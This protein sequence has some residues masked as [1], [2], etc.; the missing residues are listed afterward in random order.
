[1]RVLPDFTPNNVEFQIL[2]TSAW[3]KYYCV[4]EFAL[5][6]V[7]L[8]KDRFHQSCKE[9]FL[10]TSSISRWWLLVLEEDV[11]KYK[12]SKNEMDLSTL[13][14]R[15]MDN[16]DSYFEDMESTLVLDK[17]HFDPG[18]A[19]LFLKIFENIKPQLLKKIRRS[20]KD[21]IEN[22]F[23]SV[24]EYMSYLMEH[25]LHILYEMDYLYY[26]KNN[27]DNYLPFLSIDFIDVNLNI[28]RNTSLVIK[29]LEIYKEF[30]LIKEEQYWAV[31]SYCTR[32]YLDSDYQVFER[33]SKLLSEIELQGIRISCIM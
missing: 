23:H 31:K 22:N 29:R 28:D 9:I 3:K 12:Y 4:R 25:F 21:S 32:N 16:L 10:Y 5:N 15:S 24:V 8:G 30:D 2:A 26:N 20:L 7:I 33:Y 18:Y 11:K 1:M 27:K 19:K 17:E 13:V 14:Q 6:Q